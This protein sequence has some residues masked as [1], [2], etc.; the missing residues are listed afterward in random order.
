M[1]TAEE[2]HEFIMASLGAHYKTIHIGVAKEVL[3]NQFIYKKQIENL[4]KELADLAKIDRE[5]HAK[6]TSIKFLK[7]SDS[8]E[9]KYPGDKPSFMYN[10]E[11]MFKKF[12][13]QNKI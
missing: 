6:E 11:K 7:W 3:S 1:R 8:L 13:K 2:F 5:Q 4:A 10:H 12:K 9:S